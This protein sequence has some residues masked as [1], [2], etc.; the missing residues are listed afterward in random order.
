MV[1]AVM[2][3][4]VMVLAVMVRFSVVGRAAVMAVASVS[5]RVMP[6]VVTMM[7]PLRVPVSRW[8]MPRVMVVRVQPVVIVMAPRGQMGMDA[9]VVEPPRVPLTHVEPGRLRG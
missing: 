6:R 4:A 8:V 1:L 5:R 9:A 3:L 7:R 2:V